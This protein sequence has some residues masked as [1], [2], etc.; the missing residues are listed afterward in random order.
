MKK[1]LITGGAGFIGSNLGES[2][3]RQGWEVALL[4]IKN[5]PRN[6]SEFMDKV[7]YIN[8]DIRSQRI[9]EILKNIEPEGVIHLAAISRVVWCEER[10]DECIS[11]NVNGIQNLLNAISKLKEKPWIVFSSS[12]EVYGNPFAFPVKEDFPR[13]P[14]ST[15]AKTKCS[16]EDMVKEYATEHGLRA[17][18]LRLSNVYGNERD[19]PNR[20]IPKF[21]IRALKGKE[22][23]IYG[24]DKFFDF[25]FISDVISAIIKAAKRVEKNDEGTV[26]IYNICTGRSTKLEEL[27]EIISRIVGIG[28][29]VI[30][31]NPKAYEVR[32]YYGD[33]SKASKYLGFKPHRDINEGL[34][35]TI[36]RYRRVLG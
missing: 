9:E 32:Q 23:T 16:G 1:I 35:Y 22:I 34:E 36:I 29:D 15:Y 3:T 20:V 27:I 2:G 6:I 17:I 7:E 26:D 18:I 13:N 11:V 5:D 12:R 14:I 24:K 30:H 4:D 25:T 31:K 8:M 21:I 19:I 33:Y 10:S 28:I